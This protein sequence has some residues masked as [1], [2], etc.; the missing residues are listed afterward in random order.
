MPTAK[1]YG[2][3]T[4][5]RTLNGLAGVE[6]DPNNPPVL[7]EDFIVYA[8]HTS[9]IAAAQFDILFPKLLPAE[10]ERLIEILIR[11]PMARKLIRDP[12]AVNDVAQRADIRSG[13][14]TKQSPRGGTQT[15]GSYDAEPVT[16]R[17]LI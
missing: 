8:L 1:P 14:R 7:H 6:G 5:N 13:V 11:R 17:E 10:Q 9:K 2:Y 16:L 15:P 4:W 12:V 3:W